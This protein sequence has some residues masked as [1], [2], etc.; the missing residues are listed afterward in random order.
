MSASQLKPDER[1]L[2]CYDRLREEINTAYTHHEIAK[3]IREAKQH[4]PKEF[5]EAITFFQLS[6]LAHLIS[7]IMTIN[8]FIDYRDDS[9]KNFAFIKSN[10]YLFSTAS[11]KNR[12]LNSEC[13]TEDC[14]HFCVLHH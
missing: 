4:N 2:F 9:L 12:L 3:S 13:D 1:L 8:R 10:L 11:Y 6:M 14:E 7:S 5:S